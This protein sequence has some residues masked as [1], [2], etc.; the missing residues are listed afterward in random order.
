MSGR[1][2]SSVTT[3]GARRSSSRTSS[4]KYRYSSYFEFFYHATGVDVGFDPEFSS[5]F[6]GDPSQLRVR[7]AV[8]LMAFAEADWGHTPTAWQHSLHPRDM[9]QRISV[10]HEGVD[11]DL[12][13]PDPAAWIGLS[14]GNVRLVPGDEVVTYVARSLEP[15]RGF[16]IFM[17]AAAKILARR[18]K[19]HIVVIGNDEVSYGMRPPPSTT[20][21][22]YMLKELEGKIDL[23][24]I[25][26]LGQVNYGHYL[27]VL[28]VSAAHVYLTYPFVL[29]WSFIEA[30][31]AGCLVIGSATPPVLEVLR[32]AENGLAVDF[33]AV[34][35]LVRLVEEALD[36]PERMAPLR[37]RAR[38][39]A[40]RSFDLKRKQLPKWRRLLADMAEGK[41]FRLTS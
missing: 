2:S 1:T 4:R 28:Q 8:N 29:S 22:A 33:F 25:H 3:A 13:R 27:K 31:A 34:D 20:Y 5:V 37:R 9:Q 6:F 39:T 10:I 32:D 24:R 38:E 16:H 41:H 35:E 23:A 21:R 36:H 12:V 18:P 15:Y 11:T 19:A 14:S 30:L 7:N 40:V 26:F 17:R